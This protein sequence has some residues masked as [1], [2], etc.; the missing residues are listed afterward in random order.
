MYPPRITRVSSLFFY[1]S[2]KA[3]AII[4]AAIMQSPARTA[5]P[6]IVQN[7]EFIY[8]PSRMLGTFVVNPAACACPPPP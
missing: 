1:T 7:S 4:L 8:S 2:G 5:A 6:T 3:R